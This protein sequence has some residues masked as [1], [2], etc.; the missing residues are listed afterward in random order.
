MAKN[1]LLGIDVGTYSSKAVLTTLA[2]EIL[3]SATR[4]HGI[5]MPQPG[6]VEQ[7]ADAVRVLLDMAGLR[8]GN[9]VRPGGGAHDL[10]RQRG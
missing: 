2:G 8:H 3:R 5:S 6:H 1:L 7:D 9:A 4:P 10:T